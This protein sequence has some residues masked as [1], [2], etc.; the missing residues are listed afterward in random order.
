MTEIYT[1]DTKG[2]VPAIPVQQ[3]M[4]CGGRLGYEPGPRRSPVRRYLSLIKSLLLNP[5]RVLALDRPPQIVSR[6]G[7][8]NG[9]HP[10]LH[11]LLEK[12]REQYRSQ[13]LQFQA[14]SSYLTRIPTARV[15]GITRTAPV[16]RNPFL[17]AL[18]S[19]SLYGHLALY[20]PKRYFEI[21]SGNST[22]FARRAIEDHGLRTQI[23]SFD[24]VPRAEIDSIC[25]RCFRTRLE[26]VDLAVFDELE[27]GDIVFFDGSHHVFTNSDVVVFMLDLMPSLP[28]GVLVQLH[29]IWLPDDYPPDW[30]DNWFSEQYMLAAYLLGGSCGVE[31]VLPNWFISKDQHLSAVLAPL[32]DNSAFEGVQLHG[33]SFW[34][35]TSAR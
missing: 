26:N 7:F 6:W 25:D 35:R 11:Q 16:W 10:G 31:V 34:F 5:N 12:R 17:P 33:A 14:F 20:N 23:T 27:A 1:D 19:V 32:W 9:P 21:G 28:P 30:C 29:D 4:S 18:D 15:S 22:M 8:A 24:P 2:A 3:N 13:L